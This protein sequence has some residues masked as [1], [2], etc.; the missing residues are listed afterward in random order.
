MSSAAG[1]RAV[2]GSTVSG[3]GVGVG[4]GKTL[5]TYSV[6]PQSGQAVSPA[7]TAS[8][9]G[10]SVQSPLKDGHSS[11]VWITWFSSTQ[12]TLGSERMA[13]SGMPQDSQACLPSAKASASVC[14]G[15]PPMLWRVP[16]RWKPTLPSV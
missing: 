5:L 10:I 15:A 7:S 1:L 11:V 13:L 4:A 16:V 2:A 9:R 6:A 12:A 8:A 14:A 3:S